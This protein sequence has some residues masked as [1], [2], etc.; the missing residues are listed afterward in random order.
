[1]NVIVTLLESSMAFWIMGFLLAGVFAGL[2]FAAM[3]V[4]VRNRHIRLTLG[5][6]DG[7]GGNLADVQA[8]VAAL[9]MV[10]T[11]MKIHAAAPHLNPVQRRKLALALSRRSR[12]TLH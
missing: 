4:R 5:I 1:M 7:V 12:L 9:R 2:G 10:D 3:C 11:E 8:K 6:P